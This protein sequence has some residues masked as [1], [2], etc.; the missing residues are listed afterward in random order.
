MLKNFIGLDPFVWFIGVV[1]DRNDPLLL[2]RA[3]VRVAGW[4][5]DDK[6]L[7]PTESLPWALPILPLNHGG[8]PFGVRE[9]DYVIGF[10]KDSVNHQEPV[11][12]GVLPGIP[13]EAS[14][15]DLGFNDPTTDEA[16]Q[17][18]EVPRPPEFLT[19]EELESL[20]FNQEEDEEVEIEATDRFSDPDKLPFESTGMGQLQK[21]FT[22]EEE[23]PYNVDGD[24]DY[25]SED[26]A[27][28][29]E[30]QRTDGF[31][32]TTGGVSE[33]VGYQMS[34]YPLEPYLKESTASRLARNE[35]IEETIVAKKRGGI[36]TY[37]GASYEGTEFPEDVAVE[38]EPFQ[39][40]ET[41]Y[42][43]VPPYN[44]VY[45][46]ESGHVIEVDD[47]PGAERMHWY[48]RSGTFR[49]IHPTG[50]LVDKCVS[51]QYNVTTEDYY[52]GA[53]NVS[54]DASSNFRTKA[55][56]E[57]IHQAGGAISQQAGG[58][59]A[60]KAGA[61]T[62]VSCGGP[63]LI[64]VGGGKTEGI[65]EDYK[66]STGGTKKESVA[67]DYTLKIDGN[68][69]IEAT[70]ITLTSQTTASINANASV[71]IQ[72]AIVG[73]NAP[74]VN[75]A[76][77]VNA[78]SFIGLP[79]PTPAPIT[80]PNVPLVIAPEDEDEDVV[81]GSSALQP[82][83]VLDGPKSGVLW[84]PESDSDGKPVS[85]SDSTATH[86]LYE[87]IP[88]GELEKVQVQYLKADGSITSWDVVRPVHKKG[89]VI[90]VGRFNGIAN[91]N[92]AHFRWSK[93]AK[94]YP[95]QMILE[96]GEGE[97]LILDATIRH[98]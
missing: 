76:G 62:I 35:K 57:M 64:S 88:T 6:T 42:N 79:I 44:H 1:E 86:V 89:R 77:I 82:G 81:A 3:R 91:G 92:R 28:L 24:L 32:D 39:E 41:P 75:N 50:E 94:D 23:F 98:D 7:H 96:T 90:E 27:I 97:W 2:G 52:S 67:G 37:S 11:M 5:T 83:F 71:V 22:N 49:E 60:Q 85:L 40:P 20:D 14:N 66:L 54:Q 4:H 80:T 53:E 34:R 55:G 26:A 72:S 12:M 8:N 29:A 10:F 30:N 13:E 65:A 58:A 93:E 9:G 33:A 68:L 16:L 70:S 59:I 18:R 78:G 74:I 31:V 19:D 56:A 38:G 46:S 25:D 51:S 48:H 87:A 17:N 95:Q 21:D 61:G 15:P 73:H 36:S 47:S 63:R 69:I 45:E 84:K 43:A